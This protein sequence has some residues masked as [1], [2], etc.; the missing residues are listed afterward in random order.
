MTYYEDMDDFEFWL[1]IKD[2]AS[3][4]NE[5]IDRYGM[6]DKVI[7]SFV[8]GVLDH[9]DEE[10]SNM[11]TFFHYNMQS[12]EELEVV[13]EFMSDTY[14]DPEENQSIDDLIRG[15]GISLN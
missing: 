4:I 8:L 15:L 7:S 5:V 6:E 2:I 1:E 14:T 12:K 13:K 9:I 3:S 10:R 11:K